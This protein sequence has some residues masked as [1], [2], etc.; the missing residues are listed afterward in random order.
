MVQPPKNSALYLACIVGLAASGASR[1][2]MNITAGVTPELV[3]TD[4]L[5]L[6]PDDEQ[7]DF[8]G[9]IRPNVGINGGGGGSRV[10]YSLSTSVNVN[11]LSNSDL[12]SKCNRSNTTD[13]EQYS[14]NLSANGDVIVI[15][16]WL[17]IDANA[18]ISQ[19]SVS[20][21]I[22]GGA[23][24]EDRTGNTNTTARY[25]VNPYISRRFKDFSTLYLGYT[26]DDQWN[27]KDII[28]QSTQQT[29][30]FS[31]DSVPGSSK[32]FWGLQADY[33]N[34]NYAET[35]G[36]ESIDSE[37]S[38]ARISSGMQINRIWQ[39]NGYV[40][41]EFNDFVSISDTIDGSFWD[42]GF[43]WTP[44]SRTS[45]EIGTGD[46]FFGNTPRVAISHRYRRSLFTADY[47]KT[48][49]YSRNIRTLDNSGLPG[50][51]E[52][53]Q[54]T[55]IA[56]S[57][58]LDERFTLGYSYSHRRSSLGIAASHSD[59]TRTQDGGNSTF[60]TVSLN[61]GHSMAKKLS[62][63]CTLSWDETEPFGENSESI[64]QSEVWRA[65]L[66]A[67]RPLN[68][69]TNLTVR[70]RYT[71]RQSDFARDEY[72]ENRIT[73]TINFSL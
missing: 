32:F 18:T 55:T 4:N 64:F 35:A 45:V 29:V 22:A 11:S 46:R 49:Q 23:D 1:A 56:T 51:G 71:D 59:Q 38:S 48:L 43:R 30:L 21:F 2:D 63:S 33:D 26:Y 12:E 41:N 72:T 36:R 50:V 5:C 6:T 39:I 42:V 69:N 68:S 16:N 70:Y 24:P 25:S 8:Y 19:N 20:P 37:L 40:G 57:P 73:V 53:G 65:N 15:K 61:L 17:F 67:Q 54:P 52:P 58:I 66:S 14:P 31:L 62:L 9:I 60:K 44:N 27:S 3:Y 7:S 47:G 10:D 28:G 13:R 34:I